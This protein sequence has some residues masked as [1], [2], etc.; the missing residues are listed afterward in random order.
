MV[1]SH[2]TTIN[3]FDKALRDLG[4]SL[5]DPTMET[6]TSRS[7]LSDENTN[8]ETWLDE[9]RSH[10]GRIS[11]KELREERERVESSRKHFLEGSGTNNDDDII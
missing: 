11:E 4:D 8:L 2:H 6:S 3:S 5:V 10:S 7:S 9:V 1:E